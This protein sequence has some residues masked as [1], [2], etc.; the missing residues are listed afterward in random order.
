MWHRI[1]TLAGSVT[2]ALVGVGCATAPP[3]TAEGKAL[4]AIRS[5][6]AVGAEEV[7]EASYH[8]ELAQEQVRVA[9]QLATRREMDRARWMLERAEADAE[10]AIALTQEAETQAEAEETRR[11]IRQMRQQY[12]RSERR[13]G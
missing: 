7:P 4:S 10:L 9:R 3:T 6:R 8:L 11:R 5:A 12:L 1:S 2:L 13:P